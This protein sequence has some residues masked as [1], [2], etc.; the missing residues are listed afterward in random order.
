ME[1]GEQVYYTNPHDGITELCTIM[2]F[3]TDD[4]GTTP[5]ALIVGPSTLVIT[6][7]TNLKHE[8]PPL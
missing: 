7:L 5:R 4:T 1:I 6:N 2:E 8:M 3:R